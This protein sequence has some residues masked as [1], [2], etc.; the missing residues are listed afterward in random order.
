MEEMCAKLLALSQ[1][2]RKKEKRE[3]G[4]EGRREGGKCST[5]SFTTNDRKTSYKV[6]LSHLMVPL[7]PKSATRETKS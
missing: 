1:E 2:G 5:L 6:S 7:P 3:G 4:R